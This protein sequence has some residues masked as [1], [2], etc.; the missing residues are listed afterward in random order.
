MITSPT[1]PVRKRFLLTGLALL[2][3]SVFPSN[4]TADNTA[5]RLWAESR[6][7]LELP[8]GA[9]NPRNSEGAFI[10]LEGGEIL[11]I[12]SRFEGE[13]Y[14]DNA[15]SCLA[16][17]TS[18]DGG[19]TWSSDTIVVR[20]EDHEGVEAGPG[21]NVMSVSL[22][23]MEDGEIGL[24]YLL[25]RGWHDM[26]TQLRRSSDEGRT[27]SAPVECMPG[28]AYHVVNNDRVVRLSSGRIVIPA[29]LHRKKG[30]FTAEEAPT[31]VPWRRGAIDR[32]G[33]VLFFLSDDDGRTWR[34]S[35]GMVTLNS[36]HT[37][38]GLQEPGLVELPNGVLW[39]WA[40][41]D[42]GRQYEFFS[43]DGGEHWSEAGPSRFTSPNSPLAMKPLPRGDRFLAVWNPIP[44]YETRQLGRIGGDRTPL[45]AASGTAPAGSWTRAQVIDGDDGVDAG[46]H[47]TAI[48][49]GSDF[50]LLAY[51]AGGEEDRH[52]LNRIRMRKMPLPGGP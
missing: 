3:V 37:V 30:D 9:G 46:Y 40:R 11:F 39:G 5:P 25:R 36:P 44:N 10:E 15:Y 2:A 17:R 34:E 49:F 51:C 50:V 45:V 19:E 47:Y 7:V 4:S 32:R 13:G 52:R 1:R 26:R 28:A 16:A 33:V 8:P 18:S 14:S 20:P 35:R 24:F 43:W 31:M 41:T 21:A 38:S 29:S 6:I 48:Y 23:R 12:Y 22:L 42:M 27:W